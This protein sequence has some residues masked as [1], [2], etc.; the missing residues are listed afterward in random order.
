MTELFDKIRELE[1]LL[2]QSAGMLYG[3]PPRAKLELGTFSLKH[4]P[5]KVLSGK[6]VG[7]PPAEA[8]VSVTGGAPTRQGATP[9]TL[10]VDFDSV[11][12][13]GRFL[14]A[15]GDDAVGVRVSGSA[16]SQV[17]TTQVGGKTFE[18][19]E[20]DLGRARS[21]TLH[22]TGP[23]AK[24][25]DAVVVVVRPPRLGIGVF[26]V[27]VLPLAVLYDPP[28]SGPKKSTSSYTSSEAI[29]STFTAELKSDKS[30]DKAVDPSGPLDQAVSTFQNV[31]TN[32]TTVAKTAVA[33]GLMADTLGKAITD[34]LSL[35]SSYV[36]TVTAREITTTSS[37][38]RQ[39]YTTT[40]QLDATFGTGSGAGPGRGDR[41]L[42]LRDVELAW[43]AHTDG[44]FLEYIGA[45]S[46]GHPTVDELLADLRVGAPQ[47]RNTHLSP[48]A[49]RSVL[50]IN[51]LVDAPDLGFHA[52]IPAEPRF[53]RVLVNGAAAV[54][55]TASDV[56]SGVQIAQTIK[57]ESGDEVAN[58]DVTSQVTEYKKGLLSALGWGVTEDK[59]VT[60]TT[61]H[62]TS[63]KR[64]ATSSTKV[65]IDLRCDHPATY[66]L[67]RDRVFG[68]IAIVVDMPKLT[69]SAV[70]D[71]S[72]YIS[73]NADLPAAGITTEEQAKAHWVDYGVREGRQ[74]NLTFHAPEYLAI[75][76]DLKA[77][78]GKN[79][80]A[81]TEHY[82]SLGQKDGR[83]G[84][85]VL[86][87]AVFDSNYYHP[88]VKGS[89]L[90]TKAAWR[91]HWASTGV[92]QGLQAHPSFSVKAYLAKYKD[93]QAQFGTNYRAAIE[94]YVTTGMA[95]GRTSG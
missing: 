47:G 68:G 45:A 26:R 36:G 80:K 39:T 12:I 75:Y 9:G 90:M 71:W 62:A 53:G 72:Y 34:R 59:K 56:D 61:S 87:S 5:A 70:F 94:H 83:I 31:V 17:G 66:Q 6:Y 23:G 16:G 69:S 91:E 78:F 64:T 46:S 33:V 2:E 52:S 48:A 38:Q 22:A 27:P 35:I 67:W 77:T 86:H 43:V 55:L 82:L 19:W 93:L 21:I 15:T 20:I 49:L 95:E 18:V 73:H 92:D 40:T 10:E 74:G 29:G 60:I 81:A 30:E 76:P 32:L 13:T 24:P 65:S 1:T 14:V 4:A 25:Y 57:Y 28:Q 51:P 50:S 11:N 63:T 58:T 41:I 42:Y 3:P 85:F 37:V 44:V 79:T 88:A 7:D 84:L 8:W 54:D 89:K